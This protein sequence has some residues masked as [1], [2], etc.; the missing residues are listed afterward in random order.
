MAQTVVGLNDPKAIKKWSGSL[1][2]DTAR[3]SYFNKKFVGKS[4]MPIY[5]I[6]ELENGPGDNIQFDLSLQLKMTPISFGGC[7]A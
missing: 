7:F 6:T 2:V 4:N 5:Q 3:K 1:A